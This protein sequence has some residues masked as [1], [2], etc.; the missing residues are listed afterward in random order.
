MLCGFV[1]LSYSQITPKNG[2]DGI[3]GFNPSAPRDS[4]NTAELDSIASLEPDT[5]IYDVLTFSDPFTLT[6]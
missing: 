6:P 5:T 3:G 4:I 2:N 1:N